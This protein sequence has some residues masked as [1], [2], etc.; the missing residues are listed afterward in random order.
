MSGDS[1]LREVARTATSTPTRGCACTSRRA[2]RGLLE[3][4]IRLVFTLQAFEP[5]PSPPIDLGTRAAMDTAFWTTSLAWATWLLFAAAVVAAYFAYRTWRDTKKQLVESGAQ[6][7]AAR[8]QADAATEQLKRAKQ[9]DE[10]LEAQQVAAWLRGD[11]GQPLA[12]CVRNGNPGPVYDVRIT[13]LAKVATGN[14]PFRWLAEYPFGVV[15]PAASE[16]QGA[17]QR[18]L[19]GPDSLVPDPD[20]S[21]PLRTASA[22]FPY[23]SD[24]A[25][26]DGSPLTTGV[27]LTLSFRDSSGTRWA[28]DW[29]GKLA[30]AS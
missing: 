5:S 26:W 9:S 24:F 27:T 23:R 25:V 19:Y 13:L 17:E 11:A 20:G 8:K 16:P 22:F 10:Q 30:R 21:D 1:G 18:M 15:P 14:D 28:R 3:S 4:V 2:N 7:T 29:H 6:T 12:V